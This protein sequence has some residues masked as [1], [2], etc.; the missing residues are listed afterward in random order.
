MKRVFFI[1]VCI[2]LLF[3]LTGCSNFD[4]DNPSIEDKLNS[5]LNYIEDLIFKIVNK[6][7]KNEYTDEDKINWNYIKDDISQI[8][9]SWATIVLDLTEINVQNT[10]IMA[11]SNNL[12][13]LLI[14]ASNENETELI[15]NLSMMYE[16]I[17]GFENVY[18]DNK[19]QISKNEIK[20]GVLNTFDFVNKDEWES[21]KTEIN[22]VIQKYKELMKDNSYAE[23]NGYNLN[24]IYVLLEEYNNSI[25]TQNYNLVKIK[26]LNTI[27][28]L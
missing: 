8:N 21:A 10:D 20:S 28:N 27:E 14:S 3:S 26:Y 25:D 5:E 4:L 2:I 15:T 13:N 6:Y 22:S 16:K 17:I 7:A 24:K 12:N 11:F 23:E 19:N 1:G 18:Y 9:N